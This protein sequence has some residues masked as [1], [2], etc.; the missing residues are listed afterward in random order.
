[1][2][3]RGIRALT[4]LCVDHAEGAVLHTSATAYIQL[5]Q[6]GVHVRGVYHRAEERNRAE[7][8]TSFHALANDAKA[9]RITRTSRENESK[10]EREHSRDSEGTSLTSAPPKPTQQSRH[11]SAFRTMSVNR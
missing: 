9:S 10:A 4:A 2:N 8:E 3:H 11:D 7:A 6:Y 1:M 5:S